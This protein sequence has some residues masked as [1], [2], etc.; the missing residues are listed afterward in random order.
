MDGS[1]PTVARERSREGEERNVDKE[2]EDEEEGK[3]EGRRDVSGVRDA[4]LSPGTNTEP[5]CAAAVAARHATDS[6]QKIWL[7][8]WWQPEE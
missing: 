2:D 1:R 6:S 5:H 8:L 3:K 4:P 7:A